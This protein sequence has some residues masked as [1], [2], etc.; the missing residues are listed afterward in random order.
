MKYEAYKEIHESHKE[1]AQTIEVMRQ[2]EK[3]IV[4]FFEGQEELII[5]GCGSSYW[6]SLSIAKSFRKHTMKNVT[7][8][9]AAE[10]A[11]DEETHIK[12]YQHPILIAPSRSG[13][14]K[15]LLE[16]I[17]LFRKHYPGIKIFAVTEFVDNTLKNIADLHIAIPF[18]QEISICQTR[19]FN[20]LY[21]AMISVVSMVSNTSLLEDF[22]QYLHQAESYYQ[23][24][25]EQVQKLVETMKHPEIV[26]LSSGIQYGTAIEG[27]YII[28]E[29]AQLL[30][31]YFQTLEYRHGPIVTANEHT[32]GFIV[33][34]Q[35]E[36]LKRE[37]QMGLEMKKQKA[38]V[39][40]IGC[41]DHQ[42]DLDG[43]FA[44]DAYCEEVR[45]VYATMILQHLAY[46]LALKFNR[47][48]DKPGD[49]VKFITY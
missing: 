10:V 42:H 33:T 17:A 41:K 22:D 27:A 11:M 46:Y 23:Q 20:C 4:Q 8:L 47:N 3:G 18:A 40:L 45:G 48:P 29:M 35:S 36:N 12:G 26:V 14:S 9:K 21:T 28:M 43:T 44:I 30:T 6:A 1:M 5:L 38:N 24:A 37:C 19:S 34:T 13:E 31:N 16:S 49:L 15:E 25:D 7:V 32:Y 39:F 2:H